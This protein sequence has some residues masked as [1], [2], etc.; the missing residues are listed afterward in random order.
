MG[1]RR[2]FHIGNSRAIPISKPAF[3]SIPLNGQLRIADMY[4]E[5]IHR[6][7]AGACCEAFE[8]SKSEIKRDCY[9]LAHL[10]GPPIGLSEVI[11]F[12][13]RFLPGMIVLADFTD[14]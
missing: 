1:G 2:K 13:D 10:H 14:S 9:A 12:F 8:G 7:T 5:S 4:T 6:K 11:F 3:L